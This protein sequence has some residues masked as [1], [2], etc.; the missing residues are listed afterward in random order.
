MNE[1]P[2]QVQRVPGSAPGIE[3]DE[4]AHLPSGTG[5]VSISCIDYCQDQVLV[6]DI[7]NLEEFIV[8]HRPEWAMVRWIS[9]DG[10]SDKQAIQLLA[11]KYDLHPLA[12]E[13][14]LQ[15]KQR[16]KVEAYGG[17][18]SDFEARLFLVTHALHIQEG[19]LDHEQVSI[20]IGHKTVLTFQENR[21]TEWDAIRQRIKTKGSRLRTS[22]ASFLAYSLLDAIVD[23]CFPILES[24]GDRAEELETLILEHSQPDLINQIHQFKRAGQYRI[25]PNNKITPPVASPLTY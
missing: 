21:S 22:D 3:H 15:A 13:D 10:L 18:D 12:I 4:I 2:N 17:D 19:R 11:T 7:S 5:Q 14:M 8:Q 25:F 24:Y 16:P 20:F 9:M 1:Y 6:Q 23:R